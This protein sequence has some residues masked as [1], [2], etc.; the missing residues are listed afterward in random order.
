MTEFTPNNIFAAFEIL[1]EEIEVEIELVN[2]TGAKAFEAGDYARIQEVLTRAGQLT[3]FRDQ[4]FTLRK[5]WDTLAPTDNSED[6]DSIKRERRDLGRVQRGLR[7]R[8]ETFYQPILKVLEGFGGS[9]KVSNVLEKVEQ[10]MKGTL[11]D[12]D[13]EPLASDPDLP[14]WRNTAQWARNSMVK[15]GLLKN[16]SP[17]GTWE[18]SDEGRR[19]I[20][21]TTS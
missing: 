4:V 18:M 1:V 16:D 19:A 8:E 17:R 13:Y 20:V 9:G 11:K 14:R 21:P 6:D 5:E 10:M 7:T 2:K 12:V 15:E 3:S